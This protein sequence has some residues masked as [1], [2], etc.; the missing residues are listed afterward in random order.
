MTRPFAGINK[1]ELFAQAKELGAKT[2]NI[3]LLRITK[4]SYQAPVYEDFSYHFF[5]EDGLEVAYFVK[6][7]VEFTGLSDLS[8]SPRSWSQQAF[9]SH[10]HLRSVT[11]EML[12]SGGIDLINRSK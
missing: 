12:N 10:T 8:E 3:H 11:E 6:D 2:F 7:L 1:N 9:D 5:N 4:H